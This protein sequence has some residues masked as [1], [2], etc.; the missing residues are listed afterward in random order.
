MVAQRLQVDTPVARPGAAALAKGS[1]QFSSESTYMFL[2]PAARLRFSALSSNC[3]QLPLS[4]TVSV[5]CKISS[6]HPGQ[7]NL[8]PSIRNRR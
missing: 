4:L 5:T 1:S 7:V 3:A 8:R 2:R 6:L